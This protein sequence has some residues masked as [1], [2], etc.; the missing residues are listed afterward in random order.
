VT[1]P[2]ISDQALIR[3]L[4]LT[5]VIEENMPCSGSAHWTGQ[6]WLIAVSA[7]E[8]LVRQRF[9]LL[10]E[11]KHIIDHSVSQWLYPG[12]AANGALSERLADH[13]AGCVLMPKSWM[14]SL[15]CSG[16][17]D[18]AQLASIFVVSQRAVEVR[19]HYLGLRDLQL[20]CRRSTSDV[21]Q[22][23]TRQDRSFKEL[24]A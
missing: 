4:N 23:R 1:T 14:T 10:H 15:Y 2:P 3:H 8:P 5:T 9:S 18:P 21:V 12:S 7:D 17:S 16:N 11:T 20:H 13:F 19:L 6:N 24:A 22:S